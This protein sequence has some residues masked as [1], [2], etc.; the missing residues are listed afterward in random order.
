[1]TT[2]NTNGVPDYGM[3]ILEYPVNGASFQTD[4]DTKVKNSGT[5]FR[6]MLVYCGNFTSLSVMVGNIASQVAAWKADPRCNGSAYTDTLGNVWPARKPMIP[7]LGY[8]LWTTSEDMTFASC[9]TGANDALIEQLATLWYNAG[10]PEVHLRVD[11]ETD[12]PTTP[13]GIGSST[14]SQFGGTGAV[15][16]SWQFYNGVAA[17]WLAA[18]K[19]AWRYHANLHKKTVKNYPG[20]TV[21]CIWGPTIINYSNIPVH[22]MD[23]DDNTT[24]GNGY[25]VDA[26][27]PDFYWGNWYASDGT[28]LYTGYDQAGVFDAAFAK[29]G[30]TS[31]MATWAND[32]GT[33]YHASDFYG[34]MPPGYSGPL[35]ALPG[36]NSFSQGLGVVDVVNHIMNRPNGAPIIPVTMPETGL[37]DNSG[38]YSTAT[39]LYQPAFVTYLRSRIKAIQGLGIPFWNFNV[40]FGSSPQQYAEYGAI[41]PELAGLGSFAQP[42]VSTV[43]N[44]STISQPIV[45]PLSPFQ[46]S[47]SPVQNGSYSITA[48]KSGGSFIAP[49][50]SCDTVAEGI[51]Y[52]AAT[53]PITMTL[54][55]TLVVN[56]TV[57]FSNIGGG[58]VGTNN[59]QAVIRDTDGDVSPITVYSMLPSTPIPP[60]TMSFDI[61]YSDGSPSETISGFPLGTT[62]SVSITPPPQT[63]TILFS[64]GH[65]PVVTTNPFGTTATITTTEP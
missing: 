56:D 12:Y 65:A 37:L 13:G 20:C 32:V 43:P 4:F 3:G 25:L 62:A 54:S 59:H 14:L 18:E 39:G 22:Q 53:L 40:W 55:T 5:L 61:A 57:V 24:D 50:F 7:V 23:P 49:T 64:N 45:T 29:T 27:G 15:A 17:T 31:V 51:A 30:S 38:V 52:R 35:P 10:F 46:A 44:N 47:P 42:Q 6:T 21:K 11:Y 9:L 48:V 16:A 58:T 8:T 34:G 26:F 2:F 41:F 19:L 36:P 60:Q 63:T 33:I 1:M 28:D